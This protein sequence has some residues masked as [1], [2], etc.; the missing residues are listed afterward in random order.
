M[1]HKT[2]PHWALENLISDLMETPKKCGDSYVFTHQQGKENYPSLSIV[3]A[4]GWFKDTSV[5]RLDPL[6]YSIDTEKLDGFIGEPSSKSD[7]FRASDDSPP[8]SVTFHYED[9]EITVAGEEI[10]IRPEN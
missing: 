4:V 1:G 9:C 6:H 8:P 3:E 7:F 2:F 5:M 10:R